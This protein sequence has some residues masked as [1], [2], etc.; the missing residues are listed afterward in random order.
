MDMPGNHQPCLGGL[1]DLDI[2][3]SINIGFPSLLMS[4][5]LDNKTL[6]LPLKMLSLRS[7]SWEKNSLFN[8]WC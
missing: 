5:S 2:G 8:K 7:I 3:G 6:G 1:Y 4:L